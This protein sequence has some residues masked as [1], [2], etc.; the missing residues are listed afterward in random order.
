MIN[1]SISPAHCCKP[2]RD[3]F[4]VKDEGMLDVALL[5]VD[6]SHADHLHARA[7]VAARRHIIINIH[8]ASL[9][10]QSAESLLRR[11]TDVSVVRHY[12]SSTSNTGKI[13]WRFNTVFS[14]VCNLTLCWYTR[15]K[16]C[17]L[18]TLCSNNDLTDTFSSIFNAF[19]ISRSA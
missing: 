13:R 19:H 2:L 15:R 8:W 6:V 3:I 4:I 18:F 9:L 12:A 16:L 1:S 7:E 14:G 5:C 11:Q 17:T 10:G